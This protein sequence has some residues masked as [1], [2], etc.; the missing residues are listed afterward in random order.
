MS[1][2][3]NPRPARETAAY[4]TAAKIFCKVRLF[5]VFKVNYEYGTTKEFFTPW[6]HRNGRNV[7]AP[8]LVV[9]TLISLRLEPPRVMENLAS[10]LGLQNPQK[11]TRMKRSHQGEKRRNNTHPTTTPNRRLR[12]ILPPFLALLA[13]AFLGFGQTRVSAQTPTPTPTEEEQRLQEEKRLLDLKKAIEENKKA[14]RDAQPKASEAAAS[15]LPGNTTLDEGV[16]L[17]SAMVSYKAMSEVANQIGR[18]IK[19]TVATA[20]NFAIYDAQVIERWRLH[21]ALF[22]A[23]KGQTEDIRNHY[24]ELLCAAGSGVSTY[25]R[26]THCK[27]N[28]A[29]NADFTAAHRAEASLMK[30]EA[31]TGAI[32]AGATLIKSFIDIAAL[33]RTETKIE[34]KSVTIDNSAF[35]AEV[36]RALQNHYNCVQEPIPVGCAVQPVSL[37][38]PGAFHPRIAESETIFRIGQL[39]VFQTEAE[40]IIKATTA[41][42]PALVA[43]LN[44]LLAQ[45]AAA[46]A[47]LEKITTLKQ[48]V[49]NLNRALRY[50]RVSSFRR[51]L[52][53][54]KTEAL[55]ELAKLGGET[56]LQAQVGVLTGAI[57]GK[58]AAINAIDVPVKEL[59]DLNDRFQAFADQYLKVDASG[60]N[61]LA[62]FIKSE[63]IEEIMKGNSYWLELKSVSA[64]GNNRTRKNLIWFF[65]GARLDHS[66]GIIAEYT[67]YNQQGAVV[68]SDKIAYYN[69]YVQP[70]SIKNG[71]LSDPVQ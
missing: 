2:G 55:T 59:K 21:Q 3:I 12:R 20:N 53:E 49:A 58:K 11:G 24:V 23:F 47:N 34:G 63:D 9:L 48:E 61:I 14:I 19:S 22:P 45:K 15:A 6:P 40:R 65:A 56:D 28:T 1:G 32:G 51:K 17:E 43:Q 46:E 42:K 10:I 25:F 16:K 4:I 18:E 66:G 13:I 44:D 29:A 69:G 30:P 8:I 64:G 67:L 41:A 68:R 37:Y 26:A 38:Y 62:L 33:F 54:E 7:E 31:I 39:F 57:A 36:F 52:W 27:D 35:V 60:S 50:E 70:K 71:K 5:P